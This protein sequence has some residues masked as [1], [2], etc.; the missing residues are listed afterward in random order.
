MR[1]RIR[2]EK[3]SIITE[4]ELDTTLFDL[5]ASLAE[6]PELCDA[7]ADSTVTA[8][9][10]G[11]P[12]QPVDLTRGGARLDELG[13]LSGDQLLIEFS[14]SVPRA[15]GEAPC[16]VLADTNTYLVLRN[17][18]DDNACLFNAVLYALDPVVRV[19]PQELRGLVA[20]HIGEN[21]A[22]YCEAILGKPPAAYVAWISGKDAWG[23]AIELSAITK[24]Y[25]IRISCM[26]VES[27]K[28]IVFEQE[29]AAARFIVLVYSG[30][31]YDVLCENRSNA[32]SRAPH[33]MRRA[34][35]DRS[36]WESSRHEA[37]T[38]AG[39]KVLRNLQDHSYSTNTT[40]FRVR[41][42]ECYRV[43][44]GEHGAATHAKEFPGHLR[45][46]EVT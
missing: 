37:V 14:K 28:E 44:V 34:A 32:A 8:L 4:C 24:I 3:G 16:V 20:A 26:D 13:I 43:V 18:P 39:K 30:I 7:T 38:A 11:F 23:G 31:H 2:S 21:P 40:T 25:G 45:F 19:L 35:G 17:V 5:L 33:E 41:C 12:P 36:V 6:R 10:R 27:G 46:G 9:R 15:A 1:L 42:L 29:T 22:E